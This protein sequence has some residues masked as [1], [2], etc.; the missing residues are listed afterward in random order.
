MYSEKWSV[1]FHYQQKEIPLPIDLYKWEA[2]REVQRNS[3]FRDGNIVE[4]IL[5]EY[6]K[7]GGI[8][9]EQQSH[10]VFI[11]W[12][13]CINKVEEHYV[14]IYLGHGIKLI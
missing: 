4:D 3:K 6:Q 12:G 5:I 13:H 1:L 8:T 7:G 10:Y 9:L 2:R 11:Y 14:F